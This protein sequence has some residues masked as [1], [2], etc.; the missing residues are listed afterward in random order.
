MLL[1]NCAPGSLLLT[2]K[3]LGEI[4]FSFK[5]KPRYGVKMTPPI[6]FD[7]FGAAVFALRASIGFCGFEP[8]SEAVALTR[9]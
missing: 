5:M 2:F 9:C 3:H 1:R 4:L 7:R 8:I 6:G